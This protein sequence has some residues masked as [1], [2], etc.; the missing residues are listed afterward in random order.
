MAFELTER[1]RTGA[2]EA[3]CMATAEGAGRDRDGE[4]DKEGCVY[5]GQREGFGENDKRP[6]LR[7]ARVEMCEW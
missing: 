4:R 7:V 5:S 6:G 2:G 1:G 3:A